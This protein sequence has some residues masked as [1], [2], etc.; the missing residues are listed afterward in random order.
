MLGNSLD[1]LILEALG[2]ET[3]DLVLLPELNRKVTLVLRILICSLETAF[4]V[5]ILANDGNL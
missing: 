3:W 2:P 5:V 1:E 4:V